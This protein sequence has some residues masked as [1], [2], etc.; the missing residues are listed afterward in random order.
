MAFCKYCGKEIAEG[1]ACTCPDAM[2]EQAKANVQEAAPA[3]E[4]GYGDITAA[5]EKKNARNNLIIA[6]GAVVV[7]ILLVIIISSLAGGS[8][9]KAPLDDF[10]KGFNKC[11]SKKLLNSMYTSD[12]LDDMTDEEDVKLKELYDEM[13]EE[14]EDAFDELEDEYGKKLKMDIKVEDKKKLDKDDLEEYEDNYDDYFDANVKI[15]KGYELDCVLTIEGKD[16][17]DEEEIELVVLKIKGEGWKIYA[18]S[19]LS[20]F[21]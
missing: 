4:A 18:G 17:D 5:P 11:D 21:F 9:Y 6:G 12:M 13:D 7:L 19:S 1:T 2:N 20:M 8:G 10:V 14:L 15:S 3:A 16:D